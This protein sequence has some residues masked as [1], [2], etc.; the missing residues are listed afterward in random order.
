MFARPLQA[1]W[2]HTRLPPV[3]W[4]IGSRQV[5]HGT[6]F[7]VPPTKQAAEVL[8]VHD[9]TVIRFPEPA[10]GPPSSTRP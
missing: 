1:A 7:V 2:A 4:F 6:N 3:E 5:V 10:T 9:L 8:T